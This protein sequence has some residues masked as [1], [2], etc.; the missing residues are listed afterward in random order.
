MRRVEASKLVDLKMSKPCRGTQK[1]IQFSSYAERRGKKY[2]FPVVNHWV[3]V[4]S[5]YY[6]TEHRKRSEDIRKQNQFHGCI[7]HGG[8]LIHYWTAVGLT[9]RLDFLINL[10]GYPTH[11]RPDHI[12][13]RSREIMKVQSFTKVEN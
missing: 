10:A 2:I 4:V 1:H 9:V 5:K 6:W 7:A 11:S 12:T 3:H 13:L 8:R